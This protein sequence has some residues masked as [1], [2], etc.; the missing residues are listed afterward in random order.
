VSLAPGT[1]LGPYEILAPLGAGGMGEVYRAKDMKLGREVAVK[2]LPETFFE[3][4]ESINR[5]EREARSLAAVSH[6]HIAALFSFEEISGRHLLVM[7]LAEGETLAATITKGPLPP[8]QLLKVGIE[9]ASAL[10]AAHR[11][12]IVH[13]DLKPGNVMLTRSG[14]KLLD[15]GLAKALA[16]E[17]PVEGVTSARTAARD[18]TR[19]GEILGTLSYM[20]P[21]QLEGKKPDP[22]TDIFALGATLYEM[23]TGLKAF[24][25]T[26]QASLISVIM[27]EEPVSISQLQSMTPP[28]LERIVQ[29]CLAKN[30]DDRWQSARDVALQLRDVSAMDGG[31]PPARPRYVRTAVSA[32]LLVLAATGLTLLLSKRT[33]VDIEPVVFSVAPPG[34]SAFPSHPGET[35]FSVSPD[36]R[37]LAFVAPN[38]SGQD[39]L[40]VR[41][42]PS[43]SARPLPGTEGAAGPFWSPD[44]RWIGFFAGGR[45]EKIEAAGG[46]SL[47]ICEAPGLY[48]TGTWSRRGEILFAQLVDAAVH[49]VSAAGGAPIPAVKA[50][51]S[52]H[53]GSVCLPRFLPDSRHFLY[54]GR[55]SGS[56]QTYVRLGDMETGTGTVLVADCSRAEYADPGFLLFVRGGVLLAQPFDAAKLRVKGE[57]RQVIPDVMHHAFTGTGAFSASDNGLLAYRPSREPAQLQWLDRLGHPLGTE[58]SPGLFANV[59][60]SPDGRR[61]A[62][63]VQDP[64]MGVGSLWV[65]NVASGILTRLTSGVRD[66]FFP[67][68]SPDG[69]T[70]AFSTGSPSGGPHLYEASLN[71]GE[72]R[73]LTPVGTVQWVQD[74]SG[75]GRFLCYSASSL[76]TGQDIWILDRSDHLK[77][78]PFLATAFDEIEPQFS[79]DGRWIAYSSNESG[80]YEVYVVSFPNPGRKVRVSSTGGS[81]PRWRRDG[82]ELF[83]VSGDNRMMSAP[84]R[85]GESADVKAPQTLFS[86]DIAGWRDYDVVAD[87]TK[88]LFVLNAGEQR[89]RFISVTTNWPAALRERR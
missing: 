59:R 83:Y 61:F 70:L 60:L 76:E 32:A 89:S 27:K 19:E 80:T 17:G 48:L 67:V 58:G 71:G 65:A 5:F 25:G 7:E 2:V 53:E 74:W 51:A 14:V 81:R 15:F 84:I 45:L 13:R 46:V 62:V 57:P 55:S 79:P 77:T 69:A 64:R 41:P 43:L 86:L 49:R 54:F 82:K 9:I 29:T 18:V 34:R 50:D 30:P 4:K 38:D 75:D 24:S 6:P 12:G 42:M 68:W 8:G 40:W 21:E 33:P 72:P 31:P 26:S 85:L 47:R 3:E 35:G 56:S 44:S 28:A 20:A 39:V 78:T 10:D 88:F 16:P 87:G 1:R 63:V 23:A 52:Q 11:V 66:D 36:G 73:E 22:R 37:N